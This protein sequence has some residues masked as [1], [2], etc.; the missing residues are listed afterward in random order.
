MARVITG[1]YTSKDISLT[2]ADRRRGA[3]R[4]ARKAHR[5]PLRRVT[6]ACETAAQRDPIA[7]VG[8][9]VWCDNHAEFA[10]VVKVVE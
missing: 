9:H 6:L 8:D 5:N 2:A 10:L 1:N 3:S 4:L 7:Q